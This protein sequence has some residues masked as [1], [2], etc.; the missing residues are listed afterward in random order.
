MTRLL[1][2]GPGLRR[3]AHD[4]ILLDHQPFPRLVH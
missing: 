2:S 4:A 1:C 3:F